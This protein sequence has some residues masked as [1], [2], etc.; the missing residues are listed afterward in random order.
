MNNPVFKN[1][2]LNLKEKKQTKQTGTTFKS[3]MPGLIS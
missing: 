2:V 3:E 1:V